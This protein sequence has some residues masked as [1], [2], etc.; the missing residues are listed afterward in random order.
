MDKGLWYTDPEYWSCLKITWQGTV[1]DNHMDFLNSRM[2][3]NIAPDE[4][5]QFK[6]ALHVIL[7][8]RLTVPITVEYIIDIDTTVK[9]L[10]MCYITVT[11]IAIYNNLIE[12]AYTKMGALATGATG[13]L[14]RNHVIEQCLMNVF[15]G[16]VQ[17]V[18][19][20]SH[21]IPQVSVAMP[22]YVIIYFPKLL[23]R[24]D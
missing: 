7:Q 19:Y 3:R 1:T 21:V 22:V 14:T 18:V 12:C 23:I 15:F 13:M 2:K 6:D 24:D 8:W 9:K 5:A 11:P 4:R 20:R 16:C 10:E 17:S